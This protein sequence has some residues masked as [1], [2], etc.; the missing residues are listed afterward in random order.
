[1]GTNEHME[2][3]SKKV[4]ATPRVAHPSRAAATLAPL[5]DVKT[6]LEGITDKTHYSRHFS[7]CR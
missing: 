6:N 7:Y 2:N 3:H 1:M 4:M 5:A